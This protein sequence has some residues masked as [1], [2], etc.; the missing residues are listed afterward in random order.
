MESCIGTREEIS[1]H[2]V[3]MVTFYAEPCLTEVR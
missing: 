1:L 2:I 3:K